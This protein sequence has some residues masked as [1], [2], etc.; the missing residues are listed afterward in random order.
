MLHHYYSLIAWMHGEIAEPLAGCVQAIGAGATTYW[1]QL[2]N[3]WAPI[4]PRLKCT[5]DLNWMQSVAAT[6]VPG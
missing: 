1:N 6:S 5:H 2:V 4:L 3:Q